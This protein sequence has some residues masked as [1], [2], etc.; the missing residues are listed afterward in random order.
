M[1]KSSDTYIPIHRTLL[2]EDGSPCEFKEFILAL[3]VSTLR[4]I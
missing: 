2:I 4:A 3:A 1:S